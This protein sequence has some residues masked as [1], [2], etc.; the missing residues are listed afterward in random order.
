MVAKTMP[1]IAGSDR[2]A[3]DAEPELGS[4]VSVGPPMVGLD[5]PLS[6]TVVEDWA[7]AEAR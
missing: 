6:E 1:R 4:E 2:A 5:V 3:R 7:V